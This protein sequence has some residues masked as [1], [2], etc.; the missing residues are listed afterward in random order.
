MEIRFV[1][2]V[3][4]GCSQNK[5]K[6]SEITHN[7]SGSIFIDGAIGNFEALRITKLLTYKNARTRH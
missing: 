6:L 7:T 1:S 3:L 4:F 5:D 2:M